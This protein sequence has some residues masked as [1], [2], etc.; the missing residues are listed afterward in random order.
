MLGAVVVT[1][2]AAQPTWTP[3]FSNLSGTDTSAVVD[4]LKSQGVSYQLTN[5]GATVLVP[6]AQVYDLRVS[7]AGKNL[8][9]GDSGGWSLLDQQGMTSTDFQQNVAYQRALEGELGKTLQ[10]MSGV[11]NAIVHLAIPK[12]G[13]LLRRAPT[14]RRRPCCW[15]CSRAPR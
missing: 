13:R 10:A 9:A 14:S 15:H 11:Q 7:L 4:Q 12:P 5:G 3:L 6:E 1:R 2:F 8:P